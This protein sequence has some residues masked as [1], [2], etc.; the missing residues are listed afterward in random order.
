MIANSGNIV[1]IYLTLFD[2]FTPAMASAQKAYAKMESAFEAISVRVEK[3]TQRTFDSLAR[4]AKM[5]RGVSVSFTKFMRM[6]AFSLGDGKEKGPRK[7]MRFQLDP[8]I[9]KKMLGGRFNTDDLRDIY[10]RMP[11]PP[12]YEGVLKFA[13]GGI[14]PGA[15]DIMPAMLTPG[16]MVLPKN[17]ADMLQGLALNKGGKLINNQTGA[18]APH[19]SLSGAIKELEKY[20]Q[21]S[22]DAGLEIAGLDKLV[23]ALSTAMEIASG[24]VSDVS[25]ATRQYRAELK[26]VKDEIE[27]VTLRSRGIFGLIEATTAEVHRSVRDSSVSLV[28][29][30]AISIARGMEWQDILRETS[31]LMYADTTTLKAY[32]AAG[33]KAFQNIGA[34][35]EE[36]GTALRAAA[37]AKL[38]KEEVGPFIHDVTLATEGLE[39]MGITA[40]DTSQFVVSGLRR[41]GATTKVLSGMTAALRLGRVGWKELQDVVQDNQWMWLRIKNTGGDLDKTLGGVAGAVAAMGKKFLDVKPALNLMNAAMDP[42]RYGEVAG[43]MNLMTAYGTG[44]IKTLTDIQ[45]IAA[46]K[47]GP[48]VMAEFAATLANIPESLRNNATMLKSYGVDTTQVEQAVFEYTKF[49]QTLSAVDQALPKERKMLLFKQSILDSAD[50]AAKASAST[51]ELEKLW[52]SLRKTLRGSLNLLSQA[53]EPLFK[54]LGLKMVTILGKVANGVAWAVKGLANLFGM[55]PEWAQWGAAAI[56]LLVVGLTALTVGI[57]LVAAAMGLASAASA[58]AAIKFIAVGVAIHACTVAQVLLSVATYATAAAVWV[59]DAALAVLTSPITLVIAAIALLGLAVYGV[60]KYFGLWDPMIEGIVAGAKW[61]GGAIKDWV[62]SPLVEA[63]KTLYAIFSEGGFLGGLGA[64]WQGVVVTLTE[65]GAGVWEAITW[66]FRTAWDYISN[67]FD[68]SALIQVVI[69]GIKSFVNDA[70]ITPINAI[71]DKINGLTGYVGM[72]ALPHIPAFGDGGIVTKPTLALIGEDGPEAVVPIGREQKEQSTLEFRPVQGGG[73]QLVSANGTQ[74][75]VEVHQDEV[76]EAIERL[77]R[78][79]TG[80]PSQGRATASSVGA[81]GVAVLRSEAPF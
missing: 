75:S 62:I 21:T 64:I 10:R 26:G 49:E 37:I 30:G 33:I 42:M 47:R 71:I 29:L 45:N 52:I 14:V 61:L 32:E 25:A 81:D 28:A 60:L 67:L 78:V 56:T 11:Q 57:N 24:K 46:D 77:I 55:L 65:A 35:S 22:E 63:S 69:G 76:V 70:I 1:G 6:G 3:R 40:E 23:N 16:E 54:D 4:M 48:K 43:E 51:A 8:V 72:T 34:S 2:E 5:L 80:R 13:K 53:F 68:W 41:I 7:P 27:N 31:S 66:P 39:F 17:I 73:Q 38:S 58:W 12:S 18:F 19:A 44:A 9:P 15:T 59:L 20:R 79:F 50:A 74:V 36:V